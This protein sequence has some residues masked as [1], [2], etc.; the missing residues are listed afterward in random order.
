MTLIILKK[1]PYGV[2]LNFYK[3][4]RKQDKKKNME[5]VNKLFQE[6]MNSESVYAEEKE[7]KYTIKPDIFP[8]LTNI[9][10]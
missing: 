2:G 10:K 9:L 4:M 3:I 7:V 6:R 8:E 1:D 5:K